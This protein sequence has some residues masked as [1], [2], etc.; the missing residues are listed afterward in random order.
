MARGYLANATRDFYRLFPIIIII[1]DLLSGF[2]R[3]S[4]K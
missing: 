4:Q 3:K 1:I 2:P